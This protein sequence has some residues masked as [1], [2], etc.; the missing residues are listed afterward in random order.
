M[1]SALIFYNNI[2]DKKEKKKQSL[3]IS[4]VYVIAVFG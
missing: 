4:V 3:A 1:V 2:D